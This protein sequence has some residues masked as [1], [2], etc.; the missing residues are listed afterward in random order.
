MINARYRLLELRNVNA[1]A[2]ELRYKHVSHFS[3]DF[4][5]CYGM[6]PTEFLRRFGGYANEVI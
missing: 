6:S 2:R 5:K 4:H 3:R 1:V